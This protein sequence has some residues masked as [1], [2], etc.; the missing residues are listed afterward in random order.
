M[1]FLFRPTLAAA[2]KPS[3]IETK[4][5]GRRSKK[6]NAETATLGETFA[7]NLGLEKQPS[8]RAQVLIKRSLVLIL[9]TVANTFVRVFGTIEG[10]DIF[11]SLGYAGLWASAHA[12]VGVVYAWLG[13]EQ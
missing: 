6:F 8:H 5:K 13:N 9:C 3:L 12:F 4:A 10:T 2:G 11:G 7:H 1:F